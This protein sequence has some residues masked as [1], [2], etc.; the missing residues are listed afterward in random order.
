MT[1][2]PAIWPT[3]VASTPKCASVWHERVG[4]AL[5]GALR[6]RGRRRRDLEHARG[7]AART[8]PPRAAT[9]KSAGCSSV[10]SSGSDE[11]RRRLGQA[12]GDDV[13]V[14]VDDVDRRLV[15]ARARAAARRPASPARPRAPARATA[16]RTAWR[17]AAERRRRARRRR[18]GGRPRAARS[19]RASD[20]AGA[21][22]QRRDAAAEGVADGAAVLARRA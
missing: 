1:R 18:A 15:R 8:P 2:G 20:G 17:G 21:A 3:I 10:S 14:V 4:G 12:L 7:R 9:S 16:R 19:G 6:A 22:E 13:G 5:V 11:E